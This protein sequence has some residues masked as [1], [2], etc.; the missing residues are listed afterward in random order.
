MA[1]RLPLEEFVE[2]RILG[3]QQKYAL[4]AQLVRAGR[5]YR[6]GYKFES[7]REYKENN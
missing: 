7:C 4:L 2:V 5:L 6:Q 1:G 3:G